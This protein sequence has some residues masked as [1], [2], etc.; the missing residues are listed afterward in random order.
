MAVAAGVLVGGFTGAIFVPSFAW[1]IAPLN[2]WV[3]AIVI[4]VGIVA[5]VRS[6]PKPRLLSILGY[7]RLSRQEEGV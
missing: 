6:Q 5:L 1:G 2:A 7:S 3:V 4:Y